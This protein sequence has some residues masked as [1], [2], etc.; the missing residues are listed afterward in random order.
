MAGALH[1]V[2]ALQAGIAYP[3]QAGASVDLSALAT[4]A[5]VQ[6]VQEAACVP[7]A[8]LPP[9]EAVGGSA[10]SGNACR[11]ANAV[12]PRISRV[13]ARGVTA[14]NGTA[15]VSWAAMPV[16]PGLYIQPYV[17]AAETLPFSCF[18]VAGTVTTTGATIKCYQDQSILALLALPRKAAGAGVVFDVIALPPS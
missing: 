11:L 10:G 6:Q 9:M 2:L 8:Q 7:M 4:K 16:A 13:I 15:A 18:P 3:P 12:Q 17:S 5:E 1:I 14:A